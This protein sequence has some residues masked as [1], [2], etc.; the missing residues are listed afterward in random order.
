[1]KRSNAFR[2]LVLLA[3]G[4]FVTTLGSRVFDIALLLYIKQ[5]TGSAALMGLVML[6]S[7]LPAALLAPFGGAM[8]D[9]FGRLRMIVFADLVSAALVGL[10]LV[11]FLVAPDPGLMLVVL[12]LCNA[13]LGIVGAGFTPA[14]NA[15]V[16]DLV[17]KTHLE[18]ANAGF[19]FSQAGGGAL[20]QSL[21]GLLFGL[22]GFGVTIGLNALSFALSAFSESWIRLPGR[23][24]VPTKAPT[25]RVRLDVVGIWKTTLEALGALMSRP[26]TRA[27]LLM[28]AAFHLC[29]A[30][31][32]IVLPY[33]VETALGL[34][35]S[36]FGLFMAVYSIGLLGGFALAGAIAPAKDRLHRAA[37]LAL[38]VAL[39][40]SG[41]AL[42]PSVPVLAV[43]LAAIGAGIGLIV[44]T[45]M[46][47]L[48]IV[49][50]EDQRA[51]A[52]GAAQAVGDSSLP[53]GMALTGLVLDAVMRLDVAP[54][55]PVRWVIAAAAGLA[56][57]AA[58]TG[59]VGTRR[60]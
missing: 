17:G 30:A 43:A 20:G 16:P 12:A 52:M 59:L 42:V 55:L 53:I 25:R 56:A 58:L 38:W 54:D 23:S 2:N 29:F 36:W 24:S 27:L 3:Q 37:G 4:Q 31:L 18:K 7:S 47:E 21:G 14:V 32:P 10:V 51:S 39:C 9:G 5:A 41:M 60:P 40:F 28:I 11:A 13:L 26:R 1:M 33:Y 6:F 19:R 44:V 57:L 45:L 35:A 50:P 49:A 46:T 48:Q 34:D 8:A 15:L 22:F